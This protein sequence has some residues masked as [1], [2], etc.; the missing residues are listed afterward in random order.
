VTVRRKVPG[1]RLL[2]I[3]PLTY[4]RSGPHKRLNAPRALRYSP[5]RG[6]HF[7]RPVNEMP[8]SG[9]ELLDVFVFGPGI[10]LP[11]FGFACAAKRGA[12]GPVVEEFEST[13]NT[14]DSLPRAGQQR[15][16]RG[17]AIV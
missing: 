13:S 7:K 9:V 15:F 3:S 16:V 17:C 1:N 6:A 4:S 8:N 11:L 12:D 14:D 5:F 10:L 2:A